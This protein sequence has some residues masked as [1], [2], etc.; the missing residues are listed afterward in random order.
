[1]MAYIYEYDST[2]G[3]K[4]PVIGIQ[5][6]NEPDIFARWR[7]SEKQ[8]L[9]KTTGGVMTAGEAYTKVCNSLD[10]IGKTIK[11]SNYRVYTRVNLATSTGSDAFGNANGIWSG[12]SVKDA[13]DFARRIFELDGIDIVG[14]DSYT[15]IVKDIKGI[16]EMYATKL[17]G[18]FGH[19]AE[20]DGS[21]ANSASLILATVS[22]HAGYSL[23]DLIT[24]PYFV[25]NGSSGV[26]QGILSFANGKNGAVVEKAHWA[27]TH[28]VLMGLR[29][30]AHEV[31]RV[32]GDDFAVFN[33]STDRAETNKTQTVSTTHVRIKF[34]TS[35]GAVAF[36]ID[37]GDHLDVWSTGAATITLENASVTAVRL[38]TY[39][40]D[41]T[42]TETGTASAGGAVTLA[43]S[44]LYR[45]EYSGGGG[46]SSTT[47]A[48]IGG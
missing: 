17:P 2:H 4:K 42:F 11:A 37:R 24:S 7:I 23:Y 16:A 21:Y 33:A 28:S 9:S 22:R 5:V 46:V 18:N 34:I 8:V 14:D 10:A 41:G 39:A 19:I 13:P 1:M 47:W 3:A 27:E 36:A 26:D 32:S 30:V 12:S 31:Y 44:T 35:S 45:I 43:A 6:L 40:A 20:N 15:S 29:A 48:Q 25:E 38:G